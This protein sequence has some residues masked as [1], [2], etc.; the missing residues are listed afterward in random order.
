MADADVEFE[1]LAQGSMKELVLKMDD[2]DKQLEEITGM[3]S[4]TPN[5]G[6]RDSRFLDS[7]RDFECDDEALTDLKAELQEVQEAAHPPI[8]EVPEEDHAEEPKKEPEAP[9]APM[10]EETKEPEAA[11]AAPEAAPVE[12]GGAVNR[13]SRTTVSATVIKPLPTSTL[14]ISMKTIGGI[15][16]I[17]GID[18][19]GLLASSNLRPGLEMVR[20][21]DTYIKN[22]KHARLLIQRATDKVSLE[23]RLLDE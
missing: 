1:D 11:P 4:S 19:N 3:Q 10:P 17:V 12:N 6:G 20:V 5:V 22:A 16:R 14:G 15:T 18:E 7:E 9:P 13:S 21:N 8:K 2:I 23:T